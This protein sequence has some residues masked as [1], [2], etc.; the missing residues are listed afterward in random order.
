MKRISFIFFI[1]L[2]SATA[3][4]TAAKKIYK[5]NESGVPTYSDT[6]PSDSTTDTQVIDLGTSN[7]S[8]SSGGGLKNPNYQSGKNK[9]SNSTTTT[10]DSSTDTSTSTAND[11]T[12]VDNGTTTDINTID[13]VV[14]EPS[15]T[16]NSTTDTSTTATDTS[17]TDSSSSGASTDISS[18]AD[19]SYLCLKS[20]YWES[21]IQRYPLD[22]N[23]W[24]IIPAPPV[25]ARIIYVSSSEGD[26]ATAQ[27]YT[28]SSI[29]N[30]FNPE[31]SIL[32]FKTPEKALSLIRGGMGDWV[33][34]KKGDYFTLA[35]EISPKSGASANARSVIGAY[36]AELKRPVIDTLNNYAI[37]TTALNNVIVTGLDFYASGRDPESTNF[38]GWGNDTVDA[39]GFSIVSGGMN[40][41][42]LIENNR[43][44][45][46]SIGINI[47]A[48]GDATN[49]NIVIRRNEILN[50]YSEAGHSQG[51]FGK[52]I[53][54]GVIE[55]NVYDHNG[56]YQQ[57][58]ITVALNTKS[59]GYAT[60]FNH[61]SY[62]VN[63]SNLIVR[64][65][66]ISRASSIGM[67]FTANP[68]K[69]LATNSIMVRNI[70]L[71]D[72]L[73]VEGEVGYSLDGNTTF[74]DGYRWDNINVV[75]NVMSHIGRSQPTNRNLSWGMDIRDWKSGNVCGNSFIDQTNTAITNIKG[76]GVEG[77]NDIVDVTANSFIDIGLD[78]EQY[79]TATNS[80]TVTSSDNIFI[81][82]L[83]DVDFLG[84]YL[85]SMTYADYIDGVLLD[86]KS[87]SS[88]HYDVS[89]VLESIKNEIFQY[90]AN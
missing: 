61:N 89:K 29:K 18:L 12:I 79:N 46:Y 44:N 22:N 2:C 27:I 35:R 71:A 86:L 20:A 42:I 67:K 75:G 28:S 70:L 83:S 81:P 14:A 34:F 32:A 74:Y 90:R 30:P 56:W 65:N 8:S 40:N 60:Y 69:A 76:I 3:S 10:Q 7:G 55:E 15:T 58:P 52:G 1:V 47:S 17:A 43:F 66:L 23:G 85:G 45:Y 37:K 11:S 36:G 9:N 78:S 77:W 54:Y 51:M 16:D 68:D 80:K 59:K 84:T 49:K 64:N 19:P 41:N 82:T 38:Q 57:R 4:V 33:L 62:I 39:K 73:I 87:D 25:D 53:E 26:D 63:A 48:V 13:T 88:K 21:D 72:N 50:S 6:A 24:S 5:T 31:V